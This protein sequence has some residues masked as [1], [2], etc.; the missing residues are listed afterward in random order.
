M[1]NEETSKSASVEVHFAQRLA[2]NEKK[3]RDRAMK[4][5]RKWF[6]LKSLTKKGAQYLHSNSVHTVQLTSTFSRTQGI[7]MLLFIKGNNGTLCANLLLLN[8]ISN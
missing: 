3:I 7:Y 5:L 4:K 1:A 8:T 2:A 6:E